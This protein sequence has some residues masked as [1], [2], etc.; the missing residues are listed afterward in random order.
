M[1]GASSSAYQIEGAHDADGKGP[2]VW[3]EFCKRPGAVKHGDTGNTACDHYHRYEQDADLFAQ[4]G[5]RAYRLSVSWPRVMPEGRGG[6]NAAGLDFY[7]RL[8]DALLARNIDPWVTLF[9]W[10]TPYALGLK[11]GWLN[12]QIADD[13][14]VY[15]RAVV[16]RIGDRVGHWM[17]INEP[18]CFIGW[19]LGDVSKHD[20]AGTS[21]A[22]RLLCNHHVL[23][24][25]G[26]ACD[27]IRER[28]KLA[29]TVGWAPVGVTTFPDSEKPEDIEAARRRTLGVEPNSTWNNTWYNDPVFFGHYPEDGL[30]VFGA[31]APKVLP[32]DMERICKP[33]D[34][35]GINIYQG[36][37]VRAT[38]DGFVFVHPGP[39]HPRTKFDWPVTPEAL[40]WGPRF[41]GER[42][43]VPLYMTENG[44]SGTDWVAE[45]GRVHDPQRIDFMCRY[46]KQLRKAIDDGTD[47]RG[48]FHWSVLDNLEWAEGFG[49]RF[50]LIHVDFTTLARTLKDSAHFYRRVIESN[51]RAVL[52]GVGSMYT[53]SPDLGTVGV[54]S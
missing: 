45:D 10:D 14:G 29:P 32:G 48:Y 20:K 46:L 9:H 7:D 24:A 15:V 12:R 2:S 43:K 5:I 49:Q 30:R 25:H 33:Q 27:A 52:D 28:A 38:A 54:G 11:G 16:D 40:R 3:D 34:F 18:Q 53:F 13:F 36:E 31:D 1:W 4:I 21:L 50:G 8:V 44:Y 47:M 19:G 23:L 17:T 26:E 42:Y 51:G 22:E 35:L 6:I 41:I 39:G 37:R